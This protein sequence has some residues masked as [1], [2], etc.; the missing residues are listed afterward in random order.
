M[1]Q[2]KKE[3]E[4]ARNRRKRGVGMVFVVA[5]KKGKNEKGGEG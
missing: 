3:R 1:L 2:T 5:R 4:K